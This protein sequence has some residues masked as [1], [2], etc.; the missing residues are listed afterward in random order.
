MHSARFRLWV[1]GLAAVL[2]ACATPSPNM[3]RATP[4]P[5]AGDAIVVLKLAGTGPGILFGMGPKGWGVNTAMR[6]EG[7]Q[8]HFY[9]YGFE[10][11]PVAFHVPAGTYSFVHFSPR[12]FMQV[13]EPL[14]DLPYDPR[15]SIPIRPVTLAAGEVV[16]LGDLTVHGIGFE[17]VVAGARPGTSYSLAIDEA[18][19][20]ARLEMDYPGSVP[21]MTTRPFQ[22]EPDAV[23]S[24]AAA[25]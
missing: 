13:R 15:A 19:A 2:A 5:T 16:Y 9:F 20:R 6:E 23:F 21:R 10:D 3:I 1:L 18:A 12:H 4:A 7:S 22:I 17:D 24:A 11:R 25:R 14:L 8:R